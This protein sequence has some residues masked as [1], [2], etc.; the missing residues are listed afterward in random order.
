M[1]RH[2]NHWFT[3]SLADRQAGQLAYVFL[4]NCPIYLL[5]G[6]LLAC[7]LSSLP[8]AFPDDLRPLLSCCSVLVGGPTL[9]PAAAVL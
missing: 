5:A 1:V 7:W 6:Y 8:A 4:A 3:G 2:P 9:P